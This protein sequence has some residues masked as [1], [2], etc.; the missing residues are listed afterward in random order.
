M[1]KKTLLLLSPLVLAGCSLVGDRSSYEEPS[2]EVVDR[3]G[4]QV[5]VRRYG[6]RL[7]ADV[8]M[9]AAESDQSGNSAF[10]VLFR[11]ISGEN[12]ARGKVS[13]TVPVEVSGGQGGAERG[14]T[15]SMTVPVE[16]SGVGDATRMRFFF[17]NSY[18]MATA[19][20]PLDPHITIAEVP[21]QTVMVRRYSGFNGQA[22]KAAETAVLDA[23]LAKSA[24]VPVG[25]PVFLSYDPPWTLPP[26]RRH[27]VAREIV[28]R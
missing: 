22:A 7:V 12:K 8:T 20:E 21:G 16:H 19:P 5:E 11:Y 3:M 4:G 28:P 15:V 24:Y 23:V 27:E 1:L 13:M 9:T 10:R 18:T 14:E 2:Y 26:F 6:P 25:P 17:P